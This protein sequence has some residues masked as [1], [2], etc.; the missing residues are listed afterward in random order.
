MKDTYKIN[1]LEAPIINEEWD[2]FVRASP[3]PKYQTLR[4][5]QPVNAEGLPSEV[6]FYSQ[7][8]QDKFVVEHLN[9]K[10]DGVWVDI[11]CNQSISLS[12]TYFLERNLGWR[13]ISIDMLDWIPRDWQGV[14]NKDMLYA[15]CDAL[16]LNYEEEFNKQGFPEVIDYLTIDIEEAT[17]PAM[18]L[19]PWDKYKFRVITIEHNAYTDNGEQMNIQREFLSDKGY[20]LEI[21][22]NLAG[23][24]QDDFWV[25]ND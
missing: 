22:G 23:C 6:V 14:R 8:G 16:E 17:T 7:L 9:G 24:A 20:T 1:K 2:G 13:G 21:A 4:T 18:K 11:G 12:N 3:Y 10:R 25:L 5:H 19:I 15:P